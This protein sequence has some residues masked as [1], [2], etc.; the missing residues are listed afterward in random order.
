MNTSKPN[1]MCF[2]GLDPTGGAG[3]QADIE[4]LF[5]IGCH[6]SPVVTALTVQN[7]QNTSSMVATEAALL[8]QQAR[9]VLEDM[10]IHCF[11]IG[12]LAS[13]ESVE[14]LHTLLKDYDDIPVVLHPIMI[15][16]GGYE[17]G[18]QEL[19]DAIR[20]LLL[21]LTSVLTPN[22]EEIMQFSPSSDT[23][24]ACANEI[25]D[26]G[27]QHILLTGTHAQTE[28]VVNKLYTS[29]QDITLYD[30]PR[31][32]NDYHGSGCTLAA[33]IAGYLA[34]ELNLSDAISQAQ[35]FTWEALSHGSRVGL[36]QHLP[37]RSYWTRQPQ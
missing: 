22:T 29:H 20:T 24:D 16:G 14:V 28:T 17:S 1:V 15:A 18:G 19:I 13:V 3:I 34:H 37:D 36:G 31:L 27:C 5:S 10:P 12:L 23:T 7:T 6:C 26:S 33:A 30:W 11:K 4:T 35:R 32:E 25:L 2:S 9:A 21:P 8:V